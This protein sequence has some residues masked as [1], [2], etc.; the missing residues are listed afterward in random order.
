MYV[1]CHCTHGAHVFGL[2]CIAVVQLHFICRACALQLPDT[3]RR[4]EIGCVL[5]LEAVVLG[6]GVEGGAGDETVRGAV[7]HHAACPHRI[8][9]A[10][11]TGHGTAF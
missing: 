10:L 3:V 2:A 4:D 5:E 8:A 6:Q 1:T 7:H 11:H 9:H